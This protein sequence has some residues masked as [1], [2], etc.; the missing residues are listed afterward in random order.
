VCQ[1]LLDDGLSPAAVVALTVAELPETFEAERCVELRRSLGLPCSGAAPA[2]VSGNG[3]RLD[4]AGLS[5][6][7][8]RARLVSL[9]LESNGGICRSLLRV[10]YGVPDPTEEN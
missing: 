1:A 4:A 10:R 6:W 2:L 7:L 9:S 8:R 5:L 3:G